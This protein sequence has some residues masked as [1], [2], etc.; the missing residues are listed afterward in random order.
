MR[1]GRGGGGG[2]RRPP[3]C[4]PRCSGALGLRI[5]SLRVQARQDPPG[6]PPAARLGALGARRGAAPLALAWW[7][8]AA[9]LVL[10]LPSS[11]S[12]S[13][14]QDDGELPEAPPR[15]RPTTCS[16]RASAR[17]ERAAADRRLARTR[18]PSRT[19]SSS[20]RSTSSSSSSTQQQ[21][22]TEQLEAAGRPRGPGPAAGPAADREPAAAS[23]TSR[24]SRPSHR[25][26]TR[27]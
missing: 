27:G 7:P 22:Q 25:P 8:R 4:C 1:R 9:P 18:R 23:S 13:G 14:R 12:S 6:R 3:R 26:P 16:P 19:R 5:N 24:S 21:Q 10:A 20:T 11:T 17:R 15:A 2:A